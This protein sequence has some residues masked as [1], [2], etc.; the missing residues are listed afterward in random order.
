MA[1]EEEIEGTVKAVVLAPRTILDWNPEMNDGRIQFQTMRYASVDGVV[2][3]DLFQP[4]ALSTNV[5][6]SIAEIAL[7]RFVQSGAVNERG[8]NISLDPVTGADLSKISVA[9]V[10]Q[11]IKAAFDT[12]YT[13][14]YG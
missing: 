12:L 14:Q 5:N 8:Q 7:R 13:E 11:I 4:T 10:M 6:V 2:R 1:R 9:G 3:N